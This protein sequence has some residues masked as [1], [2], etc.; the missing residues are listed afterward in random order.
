MRL[1][2]TAVG[3][4]AVIASLALPGAVAHADETHQDSHNGPVVTLVNTG[5]IDDPMEDVLEHA[6]ILG[7]TYVFD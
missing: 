7:F 3:T 5:Q 4:L 2:T 1:R 6:A